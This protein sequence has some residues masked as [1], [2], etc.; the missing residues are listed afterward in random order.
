VS[1]FEARAAAAPE[2]RRVARYIAV[3]LAAIAIDFAIYAG[4]VLAGTWY[5]AA[6]VVSLAVATTAA[7][8]GHRHWT[9]GDTRGERERTV[10]RFL[11]V[12][13]TC[14]VAS[15]ALLS[16]LVEVAGVHRIAAQAF[17]L[18]AIAAASFLVQRNWTFGSRGSREP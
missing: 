16:L 2:L 11:V 18:P 1:I 4:L 14:V 6:K 9:F 17:V 15:L 12:Q 8:L 7:Y 13:G 5:V 3:G 10:R